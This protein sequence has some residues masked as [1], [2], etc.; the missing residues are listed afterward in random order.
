[1]ISLQLHTA[2]MGPFYEEACKTHGWMNDSAVSEALAA[3]NAE[4]LKALS[5]AI[6]GLCGLQ[7][8]RAQ[9]AQFIENILSSYCIL[10]THA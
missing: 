5:A 1:M 8:M 9:Q 6:Q 3:K 4:K 10:S 7:R 2:E